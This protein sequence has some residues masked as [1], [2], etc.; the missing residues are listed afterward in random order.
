MAIQRIDNAEKFEI[1][2]PRCREWLLEALKYSTNNI[3]ENDLLNGLVER[4][5]LLWTSDNAAC[6]TSLTEWR[7]KPV[8]VLFLIGGAKG[9]AMREILLEGQPIV[10]AYAQEHSCAGLLGIGRE[11]WAKVLKPFGF[12][13][14]GTIFYKG[15]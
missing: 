7:E 5:Y 12:Q 3:G 13:T 6:V 11:Q 2:Y 14:E 8:C 9:K 15:I 10:E 4:D 1:E